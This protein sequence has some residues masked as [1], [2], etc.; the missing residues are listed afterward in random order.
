MNPIT[1]S[2]KSWHYRLATMGRQ[3]VPDSLDICAYIRTMLGNILVNMLTALFVGAI[4]F[5]LL[6]LA[7]AAVSF[8]VWLIWNQFAPTIMWEMAFGG[9]L[10]NIAF[11][12]VFLAKQWTDRMPIK[13]DVDIPTPSFVGA[14]WRSI[15]SKTCARVYFS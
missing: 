2:K 6:I 14:A 10:A 4:G 11:G 9:M 12:V 13:Y 5:S 1:F 15:K 7:V 8:W 3:Y